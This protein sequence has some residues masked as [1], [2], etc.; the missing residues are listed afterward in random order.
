MYFSAFSRVLICFLARF[1]ELLG[2][3]L[4][5][6]GDSLLTFERLLA[7]DFAG[8]SLLTFERL[9]PTGL[10]GDF[11]G[12]SLLTFERLLA[13]ELLLLTLLSFLT[14][15]SLLMLESCLVEFLTAFLIRAH[16]IGFVIFLGRAILRRIAMSTRPT[17]VYLVHC[18]DPIINPDFLEY[19]TFMLRGVFFLATFTGLLFVL[20][21]MPNSLRTTFGTFTPAFMY[22]FSTL[23]FEYLMLLGIV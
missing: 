23:F 20:S 2:E 9:L 21:P 17:L 11:A 3:E 16:K 19:E 10:V 8:D 4:L 14:G 12:D 15:D 22:A 7:T 6:A 13:E 5:L 1:K 18:L